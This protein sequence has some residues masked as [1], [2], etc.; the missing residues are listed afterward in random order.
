MSSLP[1]SI[2]ICYR[3]KWSAGNDAIKLNF[4]FN[5][6]KYINYD[7]NCAFLHEVQRFIINTYRFSVAVV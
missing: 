2:V 4:V 5:G 1:L 6:V 3:R 7:V